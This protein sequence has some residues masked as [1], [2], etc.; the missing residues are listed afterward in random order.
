ME[1]AEVS[2]V[3]H[4]APQPTHI[5]VHI[6]QDSVLAKLLLAG[7]SMLRLP[8]SASGTT[9]R[10]LGNSRVLV[11]SWVVQIVLGVLSGVLGG[12]LYIYQFSHIR[13]TGAPIWTGVVAV[14]A[15][16]AAF[17]YERRSGICWALLRILL[18]LAALCT[19]VAAVVIG[20]SYFSYYNFY[21]RD[22]ICGTSSRS[23]STWYTQAPTT[24][25]PEETDRVH[26]CFAYVSMLKTLQISLHSMLLGVWILLL[27]A[28]LAPAYVYLWKRFFTKEKTA[29]KKLVEASVI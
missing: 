4:E 15:G 9:T 29:E 11:A 20:I 25:S 5:N 3:A 27:L 28:S 21:F 1:I 19:S 7:C 23:W 26:L 13:T 14:L 8:D 17:L 16:V 18:A 6:H 22:D 10:G 12:F 24:L 2:K